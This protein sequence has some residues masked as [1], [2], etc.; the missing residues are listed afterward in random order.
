VLLTL[1][2]EWAQW[3]FIFKIVQQLKRSKAEMNTKIKQL[4][5][6]INL[7]SEKSKISELF[8]FMFWCACS[9]NKRLWVGLIAFISYSACLPTKNSAHSLG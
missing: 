5:N 8:N 4:L 3:L 7:Q 9:F 1:D 2:L 6:E